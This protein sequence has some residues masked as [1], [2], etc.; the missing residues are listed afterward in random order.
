MEYEP[1][2]RV[3]LLMTSVKEI[4]IYKFKLVELQEVTSARNDTKPE[5]TFFYGKGNE[6]HE[7]GTGFFFLH[8]N[9]ISSYEG[10]VC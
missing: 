3:G 1:P 6:S 2:H 8:E 10:T 4:S 5:Y 9:N 7:L